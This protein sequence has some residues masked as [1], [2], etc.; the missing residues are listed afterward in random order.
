MVV[1]RWI[2]LEPRCSARR[3]AIPNCVWPPTRRHV[4]LH[5]RSNSSSPI[6]LHSFLT[7]SSPSLPLQPFAFALLSKNSLQVF[8]TA[9]RIL[10][11][12]RVLERP[13]GRQD[14]QLL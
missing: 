6:D 3:Q 2:N 5:H 7:L 11:V 12:S 9:A 14:G 13:W 10:R 8:R 1:P 4:I